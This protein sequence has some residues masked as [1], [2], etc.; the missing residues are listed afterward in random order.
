MVSAFLGG[1]IGSVL[2]FLVLFVLVAIIGSGDIE[3]II[4]VNK[5]K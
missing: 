4:I 2:G 5:K 3:W 1:L